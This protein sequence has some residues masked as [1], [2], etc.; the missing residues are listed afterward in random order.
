[1]NTEAKVRTGMSAHARILIAIAVCAAMVLAVFGTAKVFAAGD[2]GAA[3][4]GSTKSFIE[5]EEPGLAVRSADGLTEHSVDGGK[6]WK[7]GVPEGYTEEELLTPP[8]DAIRIEA[9]GEFKGPSLSVRT[10]ET[11][12]EYSVDGGKTWT[13][14]VPEGVTVD[15]SGVSGDIADDSGFRISKGI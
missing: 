13:S 11:G 5:N 12:T 4:A 8:E 3:G 9:N 15:D 2:D 1:M 10:S 7:D 6:T 14:E